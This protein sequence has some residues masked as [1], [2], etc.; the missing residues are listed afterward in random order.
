MKLPISVII[1]TYNEEKK[2][3]ECLKSVYGLVEEIFIVDSYSTDKTLEIARKYTDKIYQHPFEN[4]SSQRNW[5][6]EN[7]PIKTEWLLNLD[8]DHRVT[9]ELVKELKEIFSKPIEN[10]I[11]GFLISRRTIFMGRWIKH[12]GHYPVYHA[13]LFRK[14]FGKCEQRLYD[15]HFVVMGQ[16]KKL[17]GDVIDVITDSIDKFTIRHIKWASFEAIEQLSG[18]NSEIKPI[19]F[20]NPIQRRRFLRKFYNSF[21][22]FVRP[23]LY[24]LYR[25]FF[26]LGFLDGKEGLIFHFLQGFWYRFLV[27]AKIYEMKKRLGD[28][29]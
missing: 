20:G 9:L 12:G 19:V 26:R 3:E 18:G 24:F 4:Y 22:L 14:G 11:N 2:I 23:F 25:Y 1:L 8:A 15:Q 21:P 6:L 17:K 29:G 5:A 13:I 27:D 7:L 10:N 16:L 28:S